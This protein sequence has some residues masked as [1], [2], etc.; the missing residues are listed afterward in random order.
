MRAAPEWISLWT[1]YL[2]NRFPLPYQCG[3]VST[4]SP[5]FLLPL[6]PFSLPFPT[7]RVPGPFPV[8]SSSCFIYRALEHVHKLSLSRHGFLALYNTVF[9]KSCFEQLTRSVVDDGFTQFQLCVC[10]EC[11]PEHS[12]T[13][14]GGLLRSKSRNCF[15]FGTLFK[16][17]V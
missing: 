5:L 12:L 11:G 9:R 6:I 7:P 15:V 17:S 14:I 13:C 8:G 10:N 2:C 4:L 3:G 16:S 1:I